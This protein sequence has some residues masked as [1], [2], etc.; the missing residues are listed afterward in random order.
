MNLVNIKLEKWK[1]FLSNMHLLY[2]YLKAMY[3]IHLID[4]PYKKW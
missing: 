4:I 2:I 1:E 3:L